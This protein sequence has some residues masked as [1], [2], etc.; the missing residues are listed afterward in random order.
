MS[1]QSAMDWVTEVK[2]PSNCARGA[3]NQVTQKRGAPVS[4]SNAR[5]Q[6]VTYTPIALSRNLGS[7][8]VT[9]SVYTADCKI[10]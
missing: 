5:R 9:R 7:D 4:A 3:I 10:A 2:K 6:L 1:S 8:D